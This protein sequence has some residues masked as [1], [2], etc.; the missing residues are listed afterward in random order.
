MVPYVRISYSSFGSY[1]GIRTVSSPNAGVQN[2]VP[3]QSERSGDFASLTTPITD[4]TTG[5]PFQGNIIPSDRLD[6]IAQSMLK[7]LV[8]LPNGPNGELIYSPASTTDDDQIIA[9]IDAVVS[10]NDHVSGSLYID[11]S[12]STSNLG[13]PTLDQTLTLNNLVI[14]VNVAH[15]FSSH[16]LNSL[17]IGGYSYEYQQAGT[18]PFT[19][20]TFGATFYQP[21]GLSMAQVSVSGGLSFYDGIPSSRPTQIGQLKNN[22]TWNKGNHSFS[23]GGEIIKGKSWTTTAYLKAGLFAFNGFATGNA[24]ADFILGLPSQFQQ[25][26]GAYLP[27]SS[28]DYSL[29]AQDTWR[30]SRDLT[31]NFGLRWAPTFYEKLLNGEN[32]NFIP[33][34]HSSYFPQA[35][36]G[37]VFEGDP[38]VAADGSYHSSYWDVVEPRIGLAW[39]PFGHLNWVLRGAFGEFHENMANYIADNNLSD[40]YSPTAIIN[41]PPSM[42]NPYEG[43]NDP[44]PFTPPPRNA[45]LSEREAVVFHPPENIG[46]FLNSS[47]KVP[48]TLQWNATI[49]HSL[50]NNDSVEVSYVGSHNYHELYLEG[51]NLPVYIPGQ[52]TESNI[53]ARRPYGPNIG[54]V[55]MNFPYAYGSY[56]GLLITYRHRVAYGL[57]LSANFTWQ[58]TLSVQDTDQQNGG[59]PANVA[60]NYAPADFDNPYVFNL[61]YAWNLPWPASGHGIVAALAK[62][63]TASGIFSAIAGFPVTIFSGVDNSLTGNGYDYADRV[64]DPLLSSSRS[65]SQ[66]IR[67]WFNTKAFTVNTIGTFGDAGR[68]SIRGPGALRCDMSFFRTFPLKEA[69]KLQYRLDAS[70]IFNHTVLGNPNTTVTSSAFG[71]IGSAGN[72]RI[73]QMAL[74]FVF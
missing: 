46:E 49:R 55:L 42:A 69:F 62:G 39:T 43:I 10:S 54:Q 34:E 6:P 13:L 35:P 21:P 12:P 17:T 32:S 59:D 40:P 67:E 58:K 70:N 71:T 72:P 25:Y 24:T 4:P 29:Y 14:S 52:S 26:G 50:G 56:N 22:L 38:G 68:N 15:T 27:R 53:N 16:L 20:E 31:A 65:R 9:K 23:F 44:F 63:W 19:F 41:A 33:G 47:V 57:T 60:A 73:L 51:Y 48:T 18:N 74:R 7:A 61:S 30:A 2:Y 8:P 1:Q 66:E 37:L 64:G 45:S 11:R 3:T 5:Q 28:A 36:T